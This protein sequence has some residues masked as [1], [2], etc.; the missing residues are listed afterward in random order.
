MS[1][2]PKVA[3]TV[4]KWHGKE[5]VFQ[6][7]HEGKTQKLHLRYLGRDRVVSHNMVDWFITILVYEVTGVGLGLLSLY[8]FASLRDGPGSSKRARAEGWPEV[9]ALST[10][11]SIMG[12]ALSFLLVFRLSWS[13]GRWWEAR[14]LVGTA[15]TKVRNV[16][17][18]LT[19]NADAPTEAEAK[20]ILEL[21]LVSKLYI[22]T[23]V[24]ILVQDPAQTPSQ[25]L[26]RSSK[27][28]RGL[29]KELEPA[30]LKA[31][32]EE[33]AKI[34][35][36]S[37]RRI[38]VC[39][40]WLAHAIRTCCDLDLLKGFEQATAVDC[41]NELLR[42]FYGSMKIKTTPMPGGIQNISLVVRFCFCVIIF[43][44]RRPFGDDDSDLPMD[45]LRTSLWADLDAINET[46]YANASLG[47][48][49]GLD[50]FTATADSP[51]GKQ[52]LAKAEASL[53]RRRAAHEITDAGK[54]ALEKT[55]EVT[56]EVTGVLK[57]AANIALLGKGEHRNEC[58]A[59]GRGAKHELA[60]AAKG[61]KPPKREF[62]DFVERV[63][64]WADGSGAGRRLA[65]VGRPLPEYV[66]S[67]DRIDLARIC[68]KYA[69]CRWRL[70]RAPAARG[71]AMRRCA[72]GALRRLAARGGDVRSHRQPREALLAFCHAACEQLATPTAATPASRPRSSTPRLHERAPVEAA[73][74]GESGGAAAAARCV[75]AGVKA[76]PRAAQ[77]AMLD[78]AAAQRRRGS[79]LLR[80]STRASPPRSRS[81]RSPSR[82]RGTPASSS[83]RPRATT[84]GSAGAAAVRDGGDA[85][86]PAPT[87]SRSSARRSAPSR[88]GASRRRAPRARG[89]RARAARGV[90]RDVRGAAAHGVVRRARRGRRPAAAPR[91]VVW[92]GDAIVVAAAHGLAL[93]A[94]VERREAWS[95]GAPRAASAAGPRPI[96]G[97][98][99]WR[100]RRGVVATGLADAQAARAFWRSP[101]FAA[102]HLEGDDDDG[103]AAV[104]S[105]RRGKRRRAEAPARDAR[106]PR[107]QRLGADVGHPLGRGAADA[108]RALDRLADAALLLGGLA[109]TLDD[110]QC[111]PSLA[112]LADL[113]AQRLGDSAPRRSGDDDDEPP[114][115]AAP[116]SQQSD[117]D[118]MMD[119]DSDD[120]MTHTP[121][122]AAYDEARARR[123]AADGG[124]AAA[125]WACARGARAGVELRPPRREGRGGFPGRA[126]DELGRGRGPRRGDSVRRR[127]SDA[128][129]LRP[130]GRR[131]RR[132]GRAAALGLLRDAWGE[133]PARPGGRKPATLPTTDADAWRCCR[134]G[135][136]PRAR[137]ARGPAR[138][139]ARVP[140]REAL[141][142]GARQLLFASDDAAGGAPARRASG[143]ARAAQLAAATRAFRAWGGAP[144]TAGV[145]ALKTA[146][147]FL[148]MRRFRDGGAARRGADGAGALFESYGVASHAK[149]RGAV[150]GVRRARDRWDWRRSM[151]AAGGGAGPLARPAR[152][153]ALASLRLLL[154][155]DATRGAGSWTPRN[156][157]ASSGG[158]RALAGDCL[159][160]LGARGAAAPGAAAPA[161]PRTFD[162]AK[163]KPA[164]A[165]GGAARVE[166]EADADAWLSRV[167]EVKRSTG[168]WRDV[169][170]EVDAALHARR[171]E[172]APGAGDDARSRGSWRRLRRLGLHHV[173]DAY[174]GAAAELAGGFGAEARWRAA[175]WA[176]DA[177]DDA[178]DTFDGAFYGALRRL[179][180]RDG[181]AALERLARAKTLAVDG[182]A[183]ST[184]S[185]KTV[186]ALRGRL[187][188]V[189]EASVVGAVCG[190]ARRGRLG[191]VAA[192][193]RRR[194]SRVRRL[195]RRRRRGR[196]REPRGDAPRRDGGVVRRAEAHD[197][198]GARAHLLDFVDEACA[199]GAVGVASSA[200]ARLRV[201]AGGGAAG[202][203]RVPVR[204]AQ[205]AKGSSR[206]RKAGDGPGARAEK[207]AA[208]PDAVEHLRRQCVVLRRECDIDDE[209]LENLTSQRRVLL[210]EALEAFSAVL[211]DGGA[212]A[213]GCDD[214]ARRAAS[215]AV[216]AWLARP[217]SPEACGIMAT[218]A[219]RCPAPRLRAL[220]PLLYQLSSRLAAHGDVF[221]NALDGLLL[222]LCDAAPARTVLQLVALA[223]GGDVEPGD[224][225]A[226]TFKENHA[227]EASPAARRGRAAPPRRR[228]SVQ[229]VA[230]GAPRR[231]PR[232]ARG[233][234]RGPRPGADGARAR[235]GA[236][237]RAAQGEVP[238][239]VFCAKGRGAKPLDQRVKA[240]L[241]GAAVPVVTRLGMGAAS[242][243]DA[244]RLG[245]AEPRAHGHGHPPPKIVEC[246]GADGRRHKQLVKG[247]DDVRQD[248][249]M[250]QVF[251][252]VNALLDRDGARLVAGRARIRTY[253]IV[254]L[255]PQAGVLEWVDHTIPF[256][257]YLTDRSGSGAG[258]HSRYHPSD[259]SHQECRAKLTNAKDGKGSAKKADEAR[260]RK[261]R[262]FDDICA[263]FRPAFRFFFVEHF[264]DARDW[265]DP[266]QQK[267]DSTSLQ[268]ECSAR[269]RSGK[270]VGPAGAYTRSVAA[271]AMVG[272]VLG[273]GDRHAQNILVDTRSGEQVHIDFGVAFDQ[274]KAL[275]APETV[276]FRLTRD[277]VDGMGCH[278]T[279]GAFTLAAEAT[280]KTLRRHAGEIVTIL[281]V[282]I[283][284]PLYRWMVSP[285]DARH[286]QR[287]DDADDGDD[288][289]RP[290]GGESNAGDANDDAERALFK[291]KQKLQGDEDAGHDVLSVEGQVKNLVADATDPENLCV[292]FP[293]WAPWL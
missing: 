281:D 120:G 56:Q 174:L 189:A 168:G 284:D 80:A 183:A 291:V 278:G 50:A 125:S 234:L 172:G 23:L 110:A 21:K 8:Y 268:R 134:A 164:D 256:G 226:G 69:R 130:R 79:A 6:W 225:G 146:Y 169:L 198:A 223:N 140:G 87:P 282:L 161:P 170:G 20:A 85:T 285:K 49:A 33:R 272:H 289:S 38:L 114:A 44:T 209:A 117:S 246:L 54:L 288:A 250:E 262:A 16:A 253:A 159:G 152:I 68:V 100:L 91:R 248:A 98:A 18:M 213:E 249:V 266:G 221:G 280:M 187:L 151:D 269:A 275:T 157:S 105:R 61:R 192:A 55:K 74:L 276:P 108:L 12:S 27:A 243:F 88:G 162:G 222:K 245:R 260:R 279:H 132:A 210:V 227:S 263:K 129:R 1:D 77:C 103:K 58:G 200:V 119:D 267:G 178:H 135:G 215:A 211:T 106:E 118:D 139:R 66:A 283:H 92:D 145:K 14:G 138:G 204:Q 11:T 46:L 126:G 52:R 194:G 35:A 113:A 76:A 70:R 154:A 214:L 102:A 5:G 2:K 121:A 293:G 86:A 166:V 224:K 186:A 175:D 273:I 165:L 104:L 270:S 101:L 182:G 93:G 179:S 201:A 39:H 259:L 72:A 240:L 19:A 37:P 254:P 65:A 48:G 239:A 206:K 78:Y 171:V 7:R 96:G 274:G 199:R 89:A 238:F 231:G 212:G 180:A 107:A 158:E 208:D 220:A 184:L 265:S 111:A 236:Q 116:A 90:A 277:V 235:E 185:P 202:A 261:R 196:A 173:G 219:N 42:C 13:F 142:D 176:W 45:K 141:L 143:G 191:S 205:G 34:L 43:P 82:R 287:H 230:R 153:F 94:L 75:A 112:G 71:F 36:A 95:R 17:T 271:N 150:A 218:L 163:G 290:G 26:M 156:S 247:R 228:E 241:K 128:R 217:E 30:E 264:A 67:M 233:G 207:L 99:A 255:S 63:V 149:R 4:S 28:V 22:A 136:V 251:E 252:A 147:V 123:A 292:L 24:D 83:R 59:S 160:A 109:E 181:A 51:K 81:R 124:G 155:D 60:V 127:R 133:P 188:A 10:G 31:L 62:G 115:A 57:N 29:M 286:R 47:G 237:G 190:R 131:G 32:G 148:L 242:G 229:N 144:A 177:P 258:A 195:V 15:M 9:P 167:V 3:G 122:P 232:G 53:H 41:Q 84:S 73:A 257:A 197:L 64:K 193:R 137:R 203:L 97:G 25:K 244:P 216:S 40:S